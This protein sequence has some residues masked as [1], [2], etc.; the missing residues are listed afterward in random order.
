MDDF[1]FVRI[2]RSIKQ[3]RNGHGVKRHNRLELTIPSRFKDLVKPFIGKDLI[4]D[5]KCKN[6]RIIIEA[7]AVDTMHNSS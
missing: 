6:D 3:Y 5:I 2:R 1:P 4:L 7:K